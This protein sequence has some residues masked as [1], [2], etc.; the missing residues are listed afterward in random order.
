MIRKCLICTRSKYVLLSALKRAMRASEFRRGFRGDLTFLKTV[1]V[2]VI[3]L[4]MGLAEAVKQLGLPAKYAPLSSVIIGM[5]LA[6]FVAPT[7]P[8]IFLGGIAVGLM[9][10]GLY[11]GTRALVSA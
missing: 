6:C 4:T 10:S 9:A 1:C 2:R 8:T 7:V 5:A 11:S 3:P